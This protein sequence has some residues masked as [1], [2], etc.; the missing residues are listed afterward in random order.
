MSNFK[1]IN[2]I[3]QLAIQRIGESF[4]CFQDEDEFLSVSV[5]LGNYFKNNKLTTNNLERLCFMYGP[6]K[7]IKDSKILEVEYKIGKNFADLAFVIPGKDKSKCLAIFENKMLNVSVRETV[8]AATRQI[9]HQYITPL[10]E[11]GG[12]FLNSDSN[13]SLVISIFDENVYFSDPNN[14]QNYLNDASSNAQQRMEKYG[15]LSL[16]CY[17]NVNSIKSLED[18]E[19]IFKDALKKKKLPINFSYVIPKDYVFDGT[20]NIGKSTKDIKQKMLVENLKS[21]PLYN[22]NTASPLNNSRDIS[23]KNKKAEEITKTALLAFKDYMSNNENVDEIYMSFGTNSREITYITTSSIV[24]VEGENRIRF[25]TSD[26]CLTNGQ[27]SNLG[28]ISILENFSVDKKSDLSASIKR[29]IESVFGSLENFNLQD[30]VCFI[31]RCPLDINIKGF[32]NYKLANRA[33][34]NLNNID[35]QSSYSKIMFESRGLVSNIVSYVNAQ[36]ITLKIDHPKSAYKHPDLIKKEDRFVTFSMFMSVIPFLSKSFHEKYKSYWYKNINLLVGNQSS[37]TT[38]NKT[39]FNKIVEE[40]IEKND[41]VESLRK[42]LIDLSAELES[43]FENMLDDI[44]D[45]VKNLVNKALEMTHSG[46][47]NGHNFTRIFTS[48]ESEMKNFD[49]Q[50]VEEYL[51]LIDSK[52]NEIEILCDLNYE[53]L[54]KIMVILDSFDKAYQEG[55]TESYFSFLRKGKSEEYFMGY[56]LNIFNVNLY[57]YIKNQERNDSFII[58]DKVTPEIIT[59]VWKITIQNI[60]NTSDF[61]KNNPAIAK[62][63]NLGSNK[64]DIDI[65]I[66]NQLFIKEIVQ[67]NE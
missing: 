60:K 50:N 15:Y 13:L 62:N 12:R 66:K 1:K 8:I 28:Y 43:D 9:F 31:S 18:L 17:V 25:I 16:S 55:N 37:I 10:K 67:T 40:V 61:L 7:L 21:I 14:F 24:N 57:T 6:G 23:G 49:G 65:N 54:N 42:M 19:G 26:L 51:N 52:L 38:I 41:M 59:D 30:F 11:E 29:I 36:N 47:K 56:L 20:L 27:H 22:H 39:N 63:L 33:I 58:L 46:I 35:N 5:K 32:S 2:Q 3:S 45:K 34:K 53:L 48:L 4:Y 44:E 64:K